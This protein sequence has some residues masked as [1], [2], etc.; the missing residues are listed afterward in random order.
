MQRSAD[1]CGSADIPVGKSFAGAHGQGGNKPTRMS[2]LQCARGCPLEEPT[3][4]SALLS[5]LLFAL[6]AAISL[7]ISRLTPFKRVKG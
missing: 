6:L 1:I 3:G 5:A 4:M 7:P 2:A